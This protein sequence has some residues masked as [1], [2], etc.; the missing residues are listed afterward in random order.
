MMHLPPVAQTPPQLYLQVLAA[1][2]DADVLAR[3]REASLLAVQQTSNLLRGSGKPFSCHLV[4]V[5]SLVVETGR[6]PEVVLAALLHALYQLRVSGDGNDVARRG[7]VLEGFGEEVERV[8][9]AYHAAG[10]LLPGV[11]VLVRSGLETDVRVLQLADHLEDGLDGGPWWHGHASDAGTERGSA[12]QR[13]SL[14]RGL[15]DAYAQAPALG[16]PMLLARY[17]AILAQWDAGIWPDALRSG[18]YTSFSAV[19]R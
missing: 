2:F 11:N 15:A 19:I 1:G 13:A 8:L 17:T 6:G 4:G 12:G 5:A 18:R 10:P 9:H 3:V 14:L 16:A 7:K